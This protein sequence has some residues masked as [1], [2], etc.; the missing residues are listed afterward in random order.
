MCTF[1][2]AFGNAFVAVAKKAK[3]MTTTLDLCK[4]LCR[5]RRF[6]GMIEDCLVMVIVATIFFFLIFFFYDGHSV[7]FGEQPRKEENVGGI[8]N[9]TYTAVCH[10]RTFV[11]PV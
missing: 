9:R 5:L 11:Q 2:G 4:D 8:F 7:D 10:I 1:G 6:G 3:V